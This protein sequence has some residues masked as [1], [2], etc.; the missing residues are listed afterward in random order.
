MSSMHGEVKIHEANS[1]HRNQHTAYID[2]QIH[3]TAET[4]CLEQMQIDATSQAKH[5]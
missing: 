4:S 5:F 1:E 2:T 3:K